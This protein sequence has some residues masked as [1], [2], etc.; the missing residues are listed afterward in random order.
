MVTP[1]VPGVH[2]NEPE[3]VQWYARLAGILVLVSIVA[4][5]FGEAYVPRAMVV[6]G[7]AT[8]TAR[9]ILAHETL[10]RWG[11]AAYL[12]EAFCDAALA[13]LLWVIFRSTQRNLA[14]LMLICRVI[15]TAGFAMA[16]VLWFG[17]LRVLSNPDQLG[18]FSRPQLDALAFALVRIAGFGGT[19]F[20]AFYGAAG[21]LLGWLIFRSRLVPR[22]L[23]VLVMVMGAA[24]VIHTFL[25]ILAPAYASP[26]LL[27]TAVVAFMPLTYWLLVKGVDVERWRQLVA[28]S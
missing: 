25:V 26:L 1:P 13:M 9:N 18:A 4:G 14:V 19:L 12:V 3:S 20:S 23:G 21:L 24:F 8:A 15:G 2:R 7:D 17:A 22:V 27:A 16:E 6:A 28:A 11:F 5:G 10:F